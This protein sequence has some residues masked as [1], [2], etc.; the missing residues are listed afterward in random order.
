V[1]LGRYDR[2][3]GESGGGADDCTKI[4]GIGDL[5]QH[6]YDAAAGCDLRN[7]ERGERLCFEH[8]SLMDCLR[9]EIM[10]KIGAGN[11]FDCQI[12]DILS[13]MLCGGCRR[14]KPQGFPLLRSQGF[15]N[16]VETVEKAGR[17]TWLWKIRP[18][19]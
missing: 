9:P 14:E 19:S 13:E 11:N 18:L 8:H 6:Q 16:G 2:V 17:M 10:G 15:R 4:M 1:T 7:I 12:F 5:V 3:D